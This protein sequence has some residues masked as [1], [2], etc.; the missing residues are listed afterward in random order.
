MKNPQPIETAAASGV[1]LLEGPLTEARAIYSAL[2][3]TSIMS[4][5]D[6]GGP[7]KMFLCTCAG[8]GLKL[9]EG[10][11]HRIANESAQLSTEAAP[12]PERCAN[13]EG[14][15]F[16]FRIQP[17]SARHWIRVKE[18]LAQTAPDVHEVQ[19]IQEAAP[20]RIP[21][22]RWAT[23]AAGAVALIVMFFVVRYWI[24]GSP[25]PLVHKPQKYEF[26]VTPPPP[27]EVE[28]E[29]YKAGTREKE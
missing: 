29:I 26:N 28:P 22:A 4:D 1:Q 15:E 16:Q 6:R 7:V 3:T 8:C 20:K 14:T 13:C 2:V 10:D 17:E 9:P 12:V 27:S 11:A 24:W 5:A 25:I 21:P 18:R 23:I 19:V